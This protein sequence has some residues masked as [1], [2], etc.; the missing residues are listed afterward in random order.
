MT[1]PRGESS[2]A[3][4]PRPG[5]TAPPL[6][7][8]DRNGAPWKASAAIGTALG[9]VAVYR[10]GWCADCRRFVTALDAMAPRL[11]ALGVEVSAISVDEPEALQE[12]W[13]VWKLSSIALVGGA[14][15]AEARAWGLF[16]SRLTMH[17]AERFCLEPGLFLLRPA[18]VLY[19]LWLQSLPSARPDLEW[20]LETIEYLASHGFPLRGAD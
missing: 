18:N 1:V 13:N 7:G 9:L 5:L 11:A 4:R 6:T 17:G 16:A 15:M 8:R 12:C 2:S 19:A 10:G 20:L 3:E 14:S